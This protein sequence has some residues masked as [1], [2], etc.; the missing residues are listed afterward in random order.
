MVTGLPLNVQFRSRESQASIQ[1]TKDLAVVDGA[2]KS[3]RE[4]H[5]DAF[6][7]VVKPMHVQGVRAYDTVF[8]RPLRCSKITRTVSP[9]VEC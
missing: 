4:L 6:T 2:G 8:I 5:T 7:S 1:Q 9:T 3:D